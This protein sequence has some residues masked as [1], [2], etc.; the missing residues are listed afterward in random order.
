MF[1]Q[2]DLVV[3]Q[4][5]FLLCEYQ[6]QLVMEIFNENIQDLLVQPGNNASATTASNNNKASSR[7]TTPTNPSNTGSYINALV[8]ANLDI[9]SFHI[10]RGDGYRIQ[11][12]HR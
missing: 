2:I 7:P 3:S 11:N 12:D 9:I 4:I 5:A 8:K 1:I 6:L 10:L